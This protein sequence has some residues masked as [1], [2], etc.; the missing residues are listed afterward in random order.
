MLARTKSLTPKEIAAAVKPSGALERARAA[1]AEANERYGAI[2]A[3]VTGLCADD[4]KRNANSAL[5]N[6]LVADEAKIHGELQDARIKVAPLR[7]THGAAVAQAL[8]PLRQ[9]T[10]AKIVELIVELKPLMAIIDESMVEIERAGGQTVRM[11][12]GA[13]AD[14]DHTA[15]RIAGQAAQ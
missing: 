4:A 2:R 15:R 1:V 3:R 8:A 13:L 6:S 14:V 11:P 12:L 7:A 10:A 9:E 5:I